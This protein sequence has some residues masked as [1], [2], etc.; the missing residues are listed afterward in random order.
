MILKKDSAD[1]VLAVKV[2]KGVNCKNASL[3]ERLYA[4]GVTNTIKAKVKLERG[5]VTYINKKMSYVKFPLLLSQRQINKI[6][7]ILKIK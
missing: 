5:N 6:R 4:Y 7:K 3:K 2:W 1:L